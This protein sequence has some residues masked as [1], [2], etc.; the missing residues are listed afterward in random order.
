MG[1]SILV[2]PDHRY[3][4]YHMSPV[5]CHQSQQP[6]PHTLPLLTPPLCAVGWFSK[7]ETQN[8]KKNLKHKI[9]QNLQKKRFLS[10]ANFSDKLC[11]QKS[12]GL[13]VLVAY[14]GDI[15]TSTINRHCNL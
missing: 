6:Q 9:G 3:V 5:T 1:I 14:G 12:P 15:N 8:P 7:T 13:L 2:I 4:L 11:D 10:F